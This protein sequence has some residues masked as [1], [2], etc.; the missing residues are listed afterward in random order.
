MENPD[1][2]IRSG[3]TKLKESDY[4]QRMVGSDQRQSGGLVDK[5]TCRTFHPE[6]S[7]YIRLDHLVSLTQ[8]VERVEWQGESHAKTLVPQILCFV[9]GHTCSDA[10]RTTSESTPFLRSCS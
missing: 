8:T 6:L 4:L 7:C 5:V 2:Q 10:A 1:V 9:V 3:E